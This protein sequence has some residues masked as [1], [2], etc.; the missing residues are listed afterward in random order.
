MY[1]EVGTI[2]FVPFL[3]VYT[4]AGT[5]FFPFLSIYTDVGTFLQKLAHSSFLFSLFIHTV[6]EVLLYVPTNLRF[7]RDWSTGCLLLLSRS[8]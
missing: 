8:S 2:F 5:F 4:E 1:T 6:V 3:S 7:I